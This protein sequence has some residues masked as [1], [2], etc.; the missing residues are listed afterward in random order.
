MS[1]Q[2]VTFVNIEYFNP[3]SFHD[4]MI[5]GTNQTRED[6]YDLLCSVLLETKVMV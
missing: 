1:S 6:F 3:M 4:H 5:T 2:K